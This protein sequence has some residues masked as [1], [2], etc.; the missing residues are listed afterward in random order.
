MSFY[1]VFLIICLAGVEKRAAFR[2]IPVEWTY[3]HLHI[4]LCTFPETLKTLLTVP[5]FSRGPLSDPSIQLNLL[6]FPREPRTRCSGWMPS[7]HQDN[8]KSGET[9]R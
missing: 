1:S 4:L 6:P 5:S 3:I 2:Y 9:A 7:K 8:V